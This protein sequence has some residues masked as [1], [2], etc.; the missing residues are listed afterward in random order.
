MVRVITPGTYFE[1]ESCGLAGIFKSGSLYSCAYLNPATG[2]FIGASFDIKG[3]KEFLLRFSPKELIIPESIDPKQLEVELFTNKV[4]E[5]YFYQG[6]R[7]LIESM[8]VYNPR[9]WGFEREEEILPFGAVYLY[10]K[11]T[12]RAFLPFIQKPKPYRDEGYVYIDYRTRR[13]LEILESYEGSERFTLFWFH[14]QNSD[15]YGKKK[16]QV[17][18]NTSL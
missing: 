6:V 9:G 5:D 15:G 2:E 18:P 13:G 8:R 16:A 10:M 11:Q 3:V 14:K 1:S 17:S 7:V 12:Q 4:E